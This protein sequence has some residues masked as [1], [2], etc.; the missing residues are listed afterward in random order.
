LAEFAREASARRVS[1]AAVLSQLVVEFVQLKAGQVWRRL[2]NL[3]HEL[4]Q[5]NNITRSK[6]GGTDGVI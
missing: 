6:Y 1:L 3:T 2:R 5:L 4:I